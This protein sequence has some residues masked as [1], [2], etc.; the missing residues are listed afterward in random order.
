VTVAAEGLD[1]G[2]TT[3]Y[4]DGTTVSMTDRPVGYDPDLQP[5]PPAHPGDTPPLRVSAE[6]PGWRGIQVGYAPSFPGAGATQVEYKGVGWFELAKVEVRL[7]LDIL[8][9]ATS[10]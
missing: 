7:V 10:D 5:R 6:N 3:T 9:I 2:R 1:R 8:R 4:T